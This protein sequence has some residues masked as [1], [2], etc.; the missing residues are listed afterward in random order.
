MFVYTLG[1]LVVNIAQRQ[2]DS[3]G[4]IVNTNRNGTYK[5]PKDATCGNKNLLYLVT[6]H[7]D[8]RNTM[9]SNGETQTTLKD[10][11]LPHVMFVLL[12]NNIISMNHW[13]LTFTTMAIL[14]QCVH[15]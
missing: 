7:G 4:K 2:T 3:S 15:V 5:G 9:L 12:A 6:C 11:M 14:I 8:A 13:L 10:V 1:T